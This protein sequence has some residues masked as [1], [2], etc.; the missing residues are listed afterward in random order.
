MPASAS[1]GEKM[2]DFSGFSFFK[3][4]EFLSE[5]AAWGTCT[6]TCGGGSRSRVRTCVNGGPTDSGCL[7]NL[8]EEEV[9]NEQV[10]IKFLIFCNK[11]AI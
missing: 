1:V 5:W 4:C 10:C 3:D 6:Q 2:H 8:R 11:R 7:E 9:C